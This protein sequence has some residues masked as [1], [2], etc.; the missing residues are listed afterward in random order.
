MADLSEIQSTESVKIIGASTTGLET[1]P[2]NSSATGELLTRDIFSGSGLEGAL[3][4]GTSA[5][6]V[7]VGESKLVNRKFV[8]LYN[9]SIF[10]VYWGF[11]SGVTTLTGT[12]IQRDSLMSWAA[13][14]VTTIYVIATTADHNTRITECT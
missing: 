1:T 9:N 10:P 8:T 13:S 5:V 2:V 6:E 11:T 14:D 4:V 12:P 3:T 7:K